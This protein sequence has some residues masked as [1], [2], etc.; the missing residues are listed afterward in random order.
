[1]EDEQKF[2]L[3]SNI[4]NTGVKL[5]EALNRNNLAEA[6]LITQESE[7]TVKDIINSDKDK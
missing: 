2:L 7:Q 1:M 4:L 5:I 6:L 3:I